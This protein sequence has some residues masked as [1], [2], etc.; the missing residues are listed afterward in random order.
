M[1][2][3]FQIAAKQKG[4]PGAVLAGHLRLTEAEVVD[5]RF[6]LVCRVLLGHAATTDQP[7]LAGPYDG[8]TATNG[9]RRASRRSESDAKAALA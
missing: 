2:S 3:G 4:E 9:A 8:H 7:K 1:Q 6:M 5:V